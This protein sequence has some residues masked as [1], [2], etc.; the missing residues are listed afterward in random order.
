MSQKRTF[1]SALLAL[2]VVLSVLP[3]SELTARWLLPQTI[4]LQ[5]HRIEINGVHGTFVHGV[6]LESLT[7]SNAAYDLNA[8]Q[9]ELDCHWLGLALGRLNCMLIQARSVDLAIEQGQD[10]SKDNLAEL[11]QQDLSQLTVSLPISLTI[12]R[13][14]IDSIAIKQTQ[15]DKA[16]ILIS[17]LKG[18]RISVKG[19]R[20]AVKQLIAEHQNH[21]LT[22]NASIDFKDTWQHHIEAKLTGTRF[23]FTLSSKGSLLS[24]SQYKATINQPLK[25]ELSGR[26]H[27]QKGLHLLDGVLKIDTYEQQWQGQ[28]FT[29]SDIAAKYQLAWPQAKFDG[30]AKLAGSQL[31]PTKI[32]VSGQVDNIL[33]WSH[34]AL[35]NMH[36]DSSVSSRQVQWVSELLLDKNIEISE[37][38]QQA[39]LNV[40]F[41]ATL[42]VNDGI[43]TVITNDAL[44]G[45]LTLDIESQFNLFNRYDENLALSANID[46]NF[47]A[48][49]GLLAVED[50]S[51]KLSVRT[52]NDNLRVISEGNANAVKYQQHTVQQLKWRIHF[53][54]Q[55]QLNAQA[56]SVISTNGKI[57]EPRITLSGTQEHHQVA[58][59]MKAEGLGN[60]RA[61]YIGGFQHRPMGQEAQYFYQVA[62][63]T[64][65]LSQPD[66]E[67]SI[68]AEQILANEHEIQFQKGCIKG[69][70]ALCVEGSFQE[71][72]LDV[73]VSAEQ[74]HFADNQFLIALINPSLPQPV[75]L[76]GQI[77]G[78]LAF[79]QLSSEGL[80]IEG[81]LKIPTFSVFSEDNTIVFHDVNID[82]GQLTRQEIQSVLKVKWQH[83]EGKGFFE[84]QALAIKSGTGHLTIVPESLT[85][86]TT[87]LRQENFQI[88]NAGEVEKQ[89]R[90]LNKLSIPA[91][92]LSTSLDGLQQ[93]TK[94]SI[95]LPDNDYLNADI[96]TGW[97]ITQETSI[98]GIVD[99]NIQKF[100]WLKGVAPQIDKIAVE[101]QQ[102]YNVAG[103]I[104]EPLIAGGGKVKVEQLVLEEFGLDIK[105]SFVDF[106]VKQNQLSF[107]G[108]LT[109]GLGKLN[110]NGHGQL[111]NSP[112]IEMLIAGKRIEVINSEDNQLVLSP[113][114]SAKLSRD[115]FKLRGSIVIDE[116]RLTIKTL[117]KRA[118]KVSDDQVIVGQQSQDNNFDY[119]VQVQF[120]TG[121]DV[122][123][124]AMG[125]NSK[126]SGEV[127][128]IVTPNQPIK[129]N[130]KVS[131]TEGKFTFY[132][133]ELTIEEGQLLF[134]GNAENPGIQ[135]K[136]IREID[137]VTVGV[138]ADGTVNQP[139][140]TL[141]SEPYMA[142]DEILAMLVLGRKIEDLSQSEGSAL[143]QVALTLGL[144]EANKLARSIGQKLGLKDVTISSKAVENGTRLD[145]AAKLNDRLHVGY[146]TTLDADNNV[147]TGWIIEYKFSPNIS[148]EAISGE[149]FSAT[150]NYKKQFSKTKTEKASKD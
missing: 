99:S 63:L 107:Q 7:I 75:S 83:V 94:L 79:K 16:P 58:L 146:G 150:L 131:L 39:L 62:Q 110:L 48:L 10:D 137:G 141:F 113:N 36:V 33:A 2:L 123:L 14:S 59:S 42:Q 95:T 126:V 106:N 87:H 84:Q 47:S 122:A 148:F 43:A 44:L 8:Q 129:L 132:N 139:K 121:S 88:I 136:A 127:Q 115:A 109:N 147:Q 74:W 97:P 28:Q 13:F 138:R 128:S 78:Q 17:Q 6:K 135:F 140:L 54:K 32:M 91:F 30:E 25:G 144:D 5:G 102:H 51:A 12:K 56:S 81:H 92:E 100:E 4:N 108:E 125:L 23:H 26:W 61:Q 130:G 18:Q 66:H 69:Q 21:H 98:N 120:L 105:K 50:I 77:D 55:W 111:F 38:A 46:G 82:A 53:N 64:G 35:A 104:A 143:S 73:S 22:F 114:L 117:P 142:Q 96:T 89:S 37:Q 70:G 19:N 133:Q 90:L 112:F 15:Q 45:D 1:Y 52:E 68:S 31:E 11:F 60:M 149:E 34:R 116:G 76:K 27:W 41:S 103:T 9:L 29:L 124:N 86:F 24:N 145:I 65:T 49:P 67:L 3:F 118:I 80:S 101:L 40:N 93:Q 85:V 134:L 57:I 71:S 20:F 119:D 72:A